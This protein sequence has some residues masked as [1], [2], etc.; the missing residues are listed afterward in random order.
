MKR[1]NLSLTERQ[2]EFLTTMANKLQ[3]SLSEMVR[4]ILDSEME[5][6]NEVAYQ[7][8]RDAIGK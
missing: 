6:V 2:L 3:I 1:F 8:V 5:R 4:R 7:R